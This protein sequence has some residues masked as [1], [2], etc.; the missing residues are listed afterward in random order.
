MTDGVS[1]FTSDRRSVNDASWDS[2][3]DWASGQAQ[4][5]RVVGSSLVADSS[6][7]SSNGDRVSRWAF[8]TD[9]ADTWG[10]NDANLSSNHSISNTSR[11]NALQTDGGSPTTVPHDGS[12]DGFSAFTFSLWMYWDGTIPNLYD[13]MI[14]QKRGA[15]DIAVDAV[16]GNSDLRCRAWGP[17]GT[18]YSVFSADSVEP[19]V[20]NCWTFVFAD[21]SLQLY[22]NGEIDSTTSGP[23]S[24]N[25][26]TNRLYW[27][28]DFN[29]ANG[30]SG[31]IQDSRVYSKALSGDEVWSLYTT[32]G[33]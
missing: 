14:A 11:G 17:D 31:Y 4:D 6:T 28:N 26:S 21:G 15:Y 2:D 9:G 23:A 27:G 22:K 20:W 16:H 29:G 10:G 5:V 32:G 3:A 30:F 7:Y 8:A 1:R 18:R 33:I 19:D 24:V 13:P 25:S 12:L